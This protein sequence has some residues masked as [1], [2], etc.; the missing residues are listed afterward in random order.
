MKRTIRWE[1]VLAS[2]IH[3]MDEEHRQLI[4]GAAA[5]E[6]AFAANNP[7]ALGRA[8]EMILA[9]AKA[10]FENE[11]LAM[12][13]HLYPF[14]D[15]AAHKQEHDEFLTQLRFFHARLGK[16]GANLHGDIME[17][18]SAWLIAHILGQDRR[19]SMHLSVRAA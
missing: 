3:F 6:A 16:C 17:F 2:G 14:H 9:H 5:L 10:H 15:Y 1:P 12:Q 7:A 19:M 4:D 13:Q 18:V 8:F 11:E